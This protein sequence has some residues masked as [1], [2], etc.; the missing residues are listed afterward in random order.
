MDFLAFRV[1]KLWP[2]Y[3]KFHREFL[4]NLDFLA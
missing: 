3:L 4:K 2:K 1:P